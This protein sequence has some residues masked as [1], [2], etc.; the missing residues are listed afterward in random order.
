MGKEGFS[1]IGVPCSVFPVGVAGMDAVVK[2]TLSATIP[3]AA[4]ELA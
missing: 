3:A 1:A 4:N 2:L